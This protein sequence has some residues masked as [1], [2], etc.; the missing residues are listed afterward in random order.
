MKTKKSKSEMLKASFYYTLH[1]TTMS[2]PFY[3]SEKLESDN[4]KWAEIEVGDLTCHVN[5]A[6]NGI[7]V[8]LWLHREGEQDHVITVWGVYFS[9]LVYLGPKLLFDPAVLKLNTIVFHMHGGYFT[10]SE[11]LKE[12]APPKIRNTSVVVSAADARPSYNVNLLLRL[13]TIQQAIK[14]QMLAAQNLREKI[15]V[16]GFTANESRENAVLRRLLNKSRPK[17][18]ERQEMMR[19]RKQVELVRF[20]VSMLSYEKSRKQT[21]LQRLEKTKSVL[22]ENNHERGLKLMDRYQNLHKDMEHL[23]EWKKNFVDMREA[24]L[25]TNAQL[26]F[27]RKQLI[28][29]LNLIYPIVQAEDKFTICGVHLPNSED[30]PGNDEV[31]I[32]VALGFAAHLVQMISVFL[33]LPLRYPIIHFGSRSKIV[34]YVAEKIP[35][36]DREFPLFFR[37]KDKLEFNYGVYL[38][39]KNIAQLRW[40]F[41]LPTQDLR[42]TLPNLSA[43]LHFRPGPN[44]LETHHRTLSGSSLDL[45]S[46]SQNASPVGS[47]QAGILRR[48]PL[49]ASNRLFEKGHRVSKSMGNSELAFQ[50]KVSDP[51]VQSAKDFA[52]TGGTTNLSYSLDK[53]LDEYEEIKKAEDPLRPAAATIMKQQRVSGNLS[54]VGSEPILTRNLRDRL[55]VQRDHDTISSGDEAQKHFLQ[56][57]QAHGPAPICSDDDLDVLHNAEHSHAV[58]AESNENGKSQP[59]VC[60]EKMHN[61]GVESASSLGDEWGVQS[62]VEEHHVNSLRSSTLHDN[63]KQY[64]L[65]INSHANLKNGNDVESEGDGVFLERNGADTQLEREGCFE[66]VGM[67]RL[68][69]KENSEL[70]KLAGLGD[71]LESSMVDSVLTRRTEAL[72]QRTASFNLVRTRHGSCLE[73]NPS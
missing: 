38:L 39:N 52:V 13:H 65:T 6:V 19:V 45:R 62:S 59:S 66:T 15:S 35:D 41:N 9:G 21:E 20:R 50:M 14:K 73:D 48:Q 43:L 57:W 29:E 12:A 7:V 32:S 60:E 11:C 1:L 56:N 53:G 36:K 25:H 24:F 72:A 42:A 17:A 22:L 27:R 58:Q 16:G 37:G 3:T 64:P 47:L 44:M 40:Y 69:S 55:V 49:A 5:A 8:R 10:A 67:K 33:Q 2:A 31:M 61:S 71:M 26:T 54:H 63:M 68:S 23:K 46:S 30:F 4:P 34:D 70:E 28:S 51:E 18:P